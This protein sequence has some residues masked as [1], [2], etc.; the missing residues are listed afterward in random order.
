MDILAPVF[1]WQSLATYLDTLLALYQRPDKIESNTFPLPEEDDRPFPEDYV[2]RGLLWA[3]TCFPETWFRDEK[4]DEE[5][6]YHKV[7]SMTTDRKERIL[8]LAHRI[9][10]D[11]KWTA[12]AIPAALQNKAF[13]SIALLTQVTRFF[14][15][16]LASVINKKNSTATETN[17]KHE[18]DGKGPNQYFRHLWHQ[19]RDEHSGH[20]IENTIIA[21][22]LSSSY[23]IITYLDDGIKSRTPILPLSGASASKSW[24]KADLLPIAT[25]FISACALYLG[26]GTLESDLQLAMIATH[27]LCLSIKFIQQKF[28]EFPKTKKPAEFIIASLSLSLT[29]LLTKFFSVDEGRYKNPLVQAAMFLPLTNLFLTVFWIRFIRNWGV[30]KALEEG[31]LITAIRAFW[32]KR[33]YTII[34]AVLSLWLLAKV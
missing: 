27:N 28:S 33:S 21:A 6:K 19:L 24:L 13:R 4:T 29:G 20:I 31:N 16:T 22:V 12:S 14:P 15:V 26:N 25:A 5:A 11:A 8:W 23:I 18:S 2:M 3:A 17:T 10:S 9:A 30:A 32:Q 34:A 7:A 1:L